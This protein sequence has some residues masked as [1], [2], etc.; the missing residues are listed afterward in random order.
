MDTDEFGRY[1]GEDR[2]EYL[3]KVGD[4]PKWLVI[5]WAPSYNGWEQSESGRPGYA[6]W[7]VFEIQASEQTIRTPDGGTVTEGPTFWKRGESSNAHLTADLRDAE[8]AFDGSVK[9]DGCCNWSGDA[10]VCEPD[11]LSSC[12]EAIAR[13]FAMAREMTIAEDMR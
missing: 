9:W 3:V 11:D 8:P 4:W 6:L 1:R 10:H 12:L 2:H 7:A 13:G 5:A